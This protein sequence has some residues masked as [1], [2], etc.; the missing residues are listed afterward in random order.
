MVPAATVIVPSGFMVMEPE[1]GVGAVPGVRVI[2]AGTTGAPFRVSLPSTLAVVA[3]VRPLTEGK[4]LSTALMTGGVTRRR[5]VAVSQL[6]GFRSSH[7]R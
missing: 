7:S 5:T 2:C 3:P 6:A 4:L 1:A